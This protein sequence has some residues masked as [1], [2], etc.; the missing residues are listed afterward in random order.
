MV[1]GKSTIRYDNHYVVVG[2]G[3][4]DSGWWDRNPRRNGDLDIPKYRTSIGQRS[5]KY[6]GSKTW[7]G[8]YTELKSI[9]DLNNFKTELQQFLLRSDVLLFNFFNS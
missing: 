9:I 5:F 3:W 4:W 7:N 1:S 6:R 8:L 2:K